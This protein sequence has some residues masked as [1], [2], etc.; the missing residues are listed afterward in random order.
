M[1]SGGR[2]S[3]SAHFSFL[4]EQVAQYFLLTHWQISFQRA[5]ASHFQLFEQFVELHCLG[6]L[7]VLHLC[8]FTQILQFVATPELKHLGF[9]HSK[10][11][12]FC[13]QNFFLL[14]PVEFPSKLESY[15]V[16]DNSFSPTSFIYSCCAKCIICINRMT[17][18]IVK[19]KQ[20]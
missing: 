18:G 6:A 9:G 16:P 10:F 13:G 8:P 5:H 19:Q 4:I 2:S 7:Q 3:Q 11:N 12:P 20:K 14:I 1:H 17:C 15:L